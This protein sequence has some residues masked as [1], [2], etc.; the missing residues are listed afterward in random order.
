M[1][2]N[3]FNKK[4]NIAFAM[5]Q[6]LLSFFDNLKPLDSTGGLLNPYKGFIPHALILQKEP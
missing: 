4:I 6:S 5:F 2:L 3:N 1:F